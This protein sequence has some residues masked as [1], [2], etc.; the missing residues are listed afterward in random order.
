MKDKISRKASVRDCQ[1][2]NALRVIQEARKKDEGKNEKKKENC[3]KI[4]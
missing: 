1:Y 2:G 4:V 3:D